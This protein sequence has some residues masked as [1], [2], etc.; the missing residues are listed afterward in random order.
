MPL[1]GAKRC[2][3][4]MASL[5]ASGAPAQPADTTRGMEQL[6]Q[7]MSPRITEK[8]PAVG[9]APAVETPKASGWS[10]MA[11]GLREAQVTGLLGAPDRIEQSPSTTRWHWEKGLDK[12]W[13][14]FAGKPRT[15]VEWRSQ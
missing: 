4:V 12:G 6:R 15:V 10:R 3:I 14:D 7:R 5:I 9:Q 11:V 2:L 13:V 1:S 8:P